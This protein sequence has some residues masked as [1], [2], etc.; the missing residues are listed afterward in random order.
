MF[1]REIYVNRRNLLKEKVG[2]GLIIFMGNNDSPRNYKDNCYNFD[3]DSSF[4][5]YFGIDLP[6]LIG[7]IDIDNKKEY[8]FGKDYTIDDIVWMGEQKSLK[9]Y[10]NDIGVENFVDKD[11]FLLFIKNYLNKTK[12]H[13]IP[14]YREDNTMLL[15]QALEQNPYE[16]NETVSIDLIKIIVAQR[17]IKSPEEIIE[18]EDA[19]NITR[20]MHLTALERVK[21]GLREYEV[22]SHIERIP[23]SYNGSASFTT[24][25]SKNSHI[26]HNHSYNNIIQERDMLVLDCGA[27]NNN[28][29][30]GDMTTSIPASG[31]FTTQQK[32]I[33]N[34]LVDVFNTAENAVK[35]GVTYKS[36]H[37]K[38]CETL[39]KGLISLNLMKGN[40]RD[41][42]N[43]GAHALFF[44]HGLGHMLG[45][46]VHDMESLGE[47]YVGYDENQERDSRF[48]FKSLRLAR[49]L[50]V[51]NV[52]TIEPG[53]YFI[54]ELIKRWKNDNKFDNII[55]YQEI[56][57]YLNFGG[58]RYE[59][60]YLITSDGVR[61]LGDKMPKTVE[62]IEAAMQ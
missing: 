9:S 38:A 23:K 51:G 34:I 8:L 52:F 32:D 49:E 3:Q 37:I 4:L 30:C 47:N 26:L 12:I 56:E 14:Q 33:Y 53:I 31:K 44:P 10:C 55:N 2:N 6:G 16:L 59:G 62:E 17:N 46:D 39:A 13:I 36:V 35:A 20:K 40:P 1:K 18:I 7:V 42:V 45:L 43:E 24:I 60:D 41:I 54:P 29:Y 11:E 27:R 48:G 25:F 58:M 57:K 22:V 5:Y 50:K 15:A 61:R 19:V 28:G 21:I